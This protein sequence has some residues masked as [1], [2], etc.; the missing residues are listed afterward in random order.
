[1]EPNTQG[2]QNFNIVGIIPTAGQKLD[3]DFPWHDSLQ[4]IGK[5]YLA[6]EK[7]VHDCAMAG[8]KTIWIVCNKEMQP[9]IRHRL[10]DYIVDPYRYF[11]TAKFANIPKKIEIPIYYVPVHPKDVDRRDS[12]A[13][14]IITGAQSSYWVSK[15]LSKWVIP[16]RYFVAFPYGMFSTFYLKDYRKYINKPTPFYVSHEGK[17]FKDN[18]YLPFTFDSEDFLRCRKKFRK[19]ETPGYRSDRSRVKAADAFTGR[20]FEHGYV[21]DQVEE[22]GA[23]VLEIPW[24]YD[25]SSW[26]GLK[27]WL[28]S[29]YSLDKPKEFILSYHEWNP[30]GV[31]NE[32][33]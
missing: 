29:D 4:P 23:N 12:L 13:W 9:L 8:C 25:V 1:M 27:K 32:Q 2:T 26:E 24:Y 6:V 31:D 16:N 20:F 33:E 30:I 15:K 19:E 21:F 28:V 3:F 18:L 7:A 17:S 22:E 10:G 11:M 5:N 14:S